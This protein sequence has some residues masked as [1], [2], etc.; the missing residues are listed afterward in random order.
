M[1]SAIEQLAALEAEIPGAKQREAEAQAALDH[2]PRQAQEDQAPLRE[3]RERVGEGEPEDPALE[4]RLRRELA[5]KQRERGLT[6]R[7]EQI[8]Y[9]GGQFDIRMVAVDQGA[10][11]HHRGAVRAREAAEARLREFVSVNLARIEAEDL[12]AAEKMAAEGTAVLQAGHRLMAAWEQTLSRKTRLY[13]L[14]GHEALIGTVPANPFA[15]LQGS[16]QEAPL[17]RAEAFWK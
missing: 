5:E 10:E 7:A 8:P 2:V 12:E 14:A 16:P 15:G 6:V 17:C 9:G 1:S 11:D 13:V 4:K 3:Y